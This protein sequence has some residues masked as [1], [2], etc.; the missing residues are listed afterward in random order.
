MSWLARGRFE[1]VTEMTIA[2]RVAVLG[3]LHEQLAVRFGLSRISHRFEETR[4]TGVTVRLHVSDEQRL[5][6]IDTD[7]S[8]CAVFV[9]GQVGET[10]FRV[11]L[12][13][14]PVLFGCQSGLARAPHRLRRN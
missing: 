5:S 4:L 6:A 12:A 9:V 13:A 2:L 3:A 8:A 7:E 11:S 1:Y 14:Y 10:A